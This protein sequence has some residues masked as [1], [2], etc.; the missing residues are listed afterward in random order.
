VTPSGSVPIPDRPGGLLLS[1]DL[2]FTAKVAGTARALGQLVTTAGN[3]ALAEALIEHW[4]PRVVFIDLAAGDLVKPDALA[5]YKRLAPEAPFIAFGSHVDTAALQAARDA[6]C[7]QVMPRS[8]FTQELPGLI[9]RYLGDGRD[10][11]PA[12]A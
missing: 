10:A 1:R 12:L 8:R 4:R 5:A 3:A 9:A 7:D 11:G 2:I 6:G